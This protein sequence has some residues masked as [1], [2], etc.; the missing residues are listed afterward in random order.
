MTAMIHSPAV[1]RAAQDNPTG[2]WA[3][4]A[5]RRFRERRSMYA[6]FLVA[7]VG[8]TLGGA[9]W[10]FAAVL[11]LIYVL[12]CAA[13]MAMCMKGHRASG[14]T[15]GA[16]PDPVSGATDFSAIDAGPR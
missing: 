11:P 7:G 1:H 12:P 5:G 16:S 8:L 6:I 3:A 9:W 14:Q 2:S 4:A 13:M 10:G 15:S